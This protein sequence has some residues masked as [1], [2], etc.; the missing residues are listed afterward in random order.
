MRD[1]AVRALE[2]VVVRPGLESRHYLEA[3][4]ALRQSGVTPPSKEAKH[5]YGIIV[6]VPVKS[7]FDTVRRTRTGALDI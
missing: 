7:G 6:D 1:A 2:A 5:V 3:W 4:Q